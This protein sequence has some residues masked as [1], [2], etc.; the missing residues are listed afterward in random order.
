MTKWSN[1]TDFMPYK[2]ITTKEVIDIIQVLDVGQRLAPD[3]IEELFLGKK[4]PTR[5]DIAMLMLKKFPSTFRDYL[6]IQGQ[7]TAYLEKLMEKLRGKRYADQYRIIVEQIYKLDN[8][9][10]HFVAEKY[11]MSSTRLAE[12]L[13]S[14]AK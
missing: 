3:T 5:A 6:Y 12:Y 10:E 8:E 11:N 1:T 2:S 4:S 14:I 7:N 9:N 13:R